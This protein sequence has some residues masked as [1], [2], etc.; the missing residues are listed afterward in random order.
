MM[1]SLVLGSFC[2]RLGV[3]SCPGKKSPDFEGIDET[4]QIDIKEQHSSSYHCSR[5]NRLYV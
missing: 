1:L 5:K 2:Q 3:L 4:L